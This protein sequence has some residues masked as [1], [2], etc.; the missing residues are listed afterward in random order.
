VD[1]VKKES[2]VTVNKNKESL[3]KYFD[4]RNFAMA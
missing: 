3:G 1:E 4:L 2:M